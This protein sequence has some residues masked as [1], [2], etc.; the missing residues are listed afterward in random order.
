MTIQPR[1]VMSVFKP[2]LTPKPKTFTDKRWAELVRT[3]NAAIS[4]CED[5]AAGSLHEDPSRMAEHTDILEDSKTQAQNRRVAMAASASMVF[6]ELHRG[7]KNYTP[8]SLPPDC[9]FAS[10]TEG[11]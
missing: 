6:D 9:E 8:G 5:F 11:V 3:M 7:D 1:D 4:A 10:V 2:R